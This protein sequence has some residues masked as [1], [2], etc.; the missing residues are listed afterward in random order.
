MAKGMSTILGLAGGVVLGRYLRLQ[1]DS[2]DR[3]LYLTAALPG[4][5]LVPGKIP[6]AVVAGIGCAGLSSLADTEI[7]PMLNGN[8]SNGTSNGTSNG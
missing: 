6:G 7:I 1:I 5:M 8:G 2:K 3:D 4:S